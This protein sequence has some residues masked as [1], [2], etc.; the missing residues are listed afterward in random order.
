M[1]ISCSSGYIYDE[2]G[3]DRQKLDY[4][5]QLKN[6]RRG[7]VKEYTEKYP[8]AVYTS[9]DPT[10]DYNPPEAELDAGG[11][12]SEAADHHEKYS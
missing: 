6:I 3:F 9:V 10:I 1:I 2:T 4:I 12:G 5:M 7:R 11:S 8:D